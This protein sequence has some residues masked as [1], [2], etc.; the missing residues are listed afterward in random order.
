MLLEMK[1]NHAIK[2]A[3]YVEIEEA[4]HILNELWSACT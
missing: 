2:I 1:D 4:Q 3:G